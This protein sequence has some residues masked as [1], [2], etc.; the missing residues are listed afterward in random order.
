MKEIG[1]RAFYPC[2]LTSLSLP[3]GLTTIGV[4]AFSG[5]GASTIVIPDS[6]TYMGGS[7]FSGS[8][9]TSITLS[10]NLTSIEAA[11]FK[12]C[13]D[14]TSIVIPEGVTIIKNEAFSTCTALTSVTLPST[15]LTLGKSAFTRC[16]ALTNITCPDGMTQIKERVFEECSALTSITLPDTITHIDDYAF[17]Y[18]GSMSDV[19]YAGTQEQWDAIYMNTMWNTG[20]SQSTIHYGADTATETVVTPAHSF[21]DVVADS[22]YEDA[23]IWAVNNGVTSGTTTTTFEPSATCTRGQVVT[24][25]WRAMGEPTPSITENPFSDVSETSVF[26][27]AI[28]WAVGEGITTGYSDGTFRPT[29]TCTTGQVLT[30]LYR[31]VG[32]PDTSYESGYAVGASSA[33]VS[34]INWADESSLLSGLTV[35]ISGASSR[36]DIVTYLYR[37]A[38]SPAV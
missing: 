19:Y 23:V 2:K 30:F 21:T 15:L 14:L 1:D 27:T 3:Y 13:Y 33:F 38:G 24:F 18:C 31:A 12:Y 29:D 8:G 20:I 25:L 9:V 35:T 6:V 10:K 36:S 28:L 34:A 5:I 17:R 37:N 22:Y 26:Y 11:T 4:A 32:E 7:A 16:Y